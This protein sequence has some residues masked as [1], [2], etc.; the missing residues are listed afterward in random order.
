VAKIGLQIGNLA[1]FIQQRN[2][3]EAAPIIAGLRE[4]LEHE[5]SVN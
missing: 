4:V 2:P 5:Y 1:H 3:Q